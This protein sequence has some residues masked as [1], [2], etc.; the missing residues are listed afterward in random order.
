MRLLRSAE[1]CG[2]ASPSALHLI[3]SS[4]CGEHQRIPRLFGCL[5]SVRG[6]AVSGT[7]IQ[8]VGCGHAQLAAVMT[9]AFIGGGMVARDSSP[10]R[11]ISRYEAANQAVQ[12]PG[13]S[14]FAQRRIQR[15]RWLAPVAD[16][17]VR[18]L[19]MM[20]LVAARLDRRRAIMPVRRRKA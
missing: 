16:L 1:P 9:L 15:H 7:P 10:R 20:M 5:S 12:R 18:R 19:R 14:R 3:R 17:S 4:S 13:A 2:T 6:R 8:T 11:T